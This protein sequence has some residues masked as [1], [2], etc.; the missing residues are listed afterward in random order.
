MFELSARTIYGVSA[1]FELAKNFSD[2]PTKVGTISENQDI[3]RNYLDQIM[4]ELKKADLVAS[5]RGI[6]GGYTLEKSPEELTVGEV[7]RILEGRVNLAGSARPDNPVLKKFW[8]DKNGELA[9]NF[10]IN[11]SK[12]LQ[13]WQKHQGTINYS[14]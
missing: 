4:L 7:I 9:E 14:I 3:P 12:L 11:F 1:V 2:E 6:D 13:L 5:H 8:E 10:E